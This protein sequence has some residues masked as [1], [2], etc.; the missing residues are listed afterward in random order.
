M[1]V[2][3]EFR[4]LRHE[5]CLTFLQNKQKGKRVFEMTKVE[6]VFVTMPKDLSWIPRTHAV[7][8]DNQLRKAV[9]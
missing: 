6:K 4:R 1:L 8:G 7:E 3:P 9:F 5:N 2:I